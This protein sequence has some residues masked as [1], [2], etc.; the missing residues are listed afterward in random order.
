MRRMLEDG[1]RRKREEEMADKR[2]SE[3]DEA[4]RMLPLM[5]LLKLLDSDQ[6]S[7]SKVLCFKSF[8]NQ[9]SA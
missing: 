7:G 1:L 9:F 5:A 4:A 8:L 6:E 2:K 3:L